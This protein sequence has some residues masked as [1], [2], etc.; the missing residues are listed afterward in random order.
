MSAAYPDRIEELFEFYRRALERE[1]LPFWRRAWDIELGGVYTCFT[2]DGSRLVSTDKYVWSQGRFLWLL[3]RLVRMIRAGILPQPDDGSGDG[4]IPAA[5]YLDQARKTCRFLL[6]HAVLEPGDGVCPFLLTREGR[7]KESVPGAGFYTS[8]Y[9]DCFVILGLSEYALTSGEREPLERALELYDRSIA[10]MADR[11]VVS[12]PYPVP[13]GF[14]S[15]S[16]PMILCDTAFGL[17]EALLRAGHP[18]GGEV[19]AESVRYAEAVLTRHYDEGTGLLRETVPLDRGNE[20]TL[21]ARHFNPGHT[22]ESMWFCGRVLE[23]EGGDRE[24]LSWA[25]GVTANGIEAGWDERSGGLFRFCDRAG[26]EPSGRLLEVPY[27]RQVCETWDTKLWWVHS[28]ALYASLF[29]HEKTG[30]ERFW[31]LHLQLGA[32]VF[33]T[34]PNPD[35]EVGEWIQIRDR[36]GAPLEKTVA[37]PVKDP[38]HI[39]RNFLLILELLS[40]ERL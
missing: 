30:D 4:P 25:A 12:E 18:R 5:E 3:S 9:V 37:L 1:I 11:G 21:L 16:V 17:S 15:H 26:G 2:N 22:V 29:F 33:S 39:M 6:E 34:F 35:R 23:A 13:P 28:E 27:E 8:F 32:Y 40:A 36:A 7:K 20:D 38:Y 14:L 24:L 10:F 31:E 19:R